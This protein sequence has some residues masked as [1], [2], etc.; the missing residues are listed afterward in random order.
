MSDEEKIQHEFDREE[1]NFE[2]PTSH[3]EVDTSP[4]E[5]EEGTAKKDVVKKVETPEVQLEKPAVATPVTEPVST[6]HIQ[7][8]Q[9]KNAPGVLVL[10]WLAYAFWGWTAASLWWL[11]ALVVGHFTN[12]QTNSYSENWLAYSFAST[13]VLYLISMAT[14]LVYAR[15]EPLH[16]T[17]AATVIM[18]IHTV[19]YSLIGIGAAITA[20]FSVV[21][22]FLET[23]QTYN[24]GA[25]TALIAAVVMMVVYA[26]LVLRILRPVS[27]AWVPKLFWISMSIITIG[28][29]A[30]SII[31]PIAESKM[32][33][34][35][36][37]IEDGLTGVSS[38]IRSYTTANKK[39]P[40][41]LS[42]VRTSLGIETSA[43]RLLDKNLVQYTPGKQVTS[44]STTTSGV[45]LSSTT[46]YNYKLC[47][48]Y[49]RTSSNRYYSTYSYDSYYTDKTTPYVSGHGAGTVCY[50]LVAKTYN[51]TTQSTATQ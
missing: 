48:K 11:T 15:K 38:G 5:H 17:G 40:A 24:D 35:D 13:L 19:V 16:K 47:V 50:D 42:D 32:T 7:V 36:R 37:L 44:Q 41:S 12:P 18:I 23:S 6:S 14:D 27:R 45:R 9:V 21:N 3:D 20:V 31:G 28:M 49:A 43:A 4:D 2:E 46:T 25:V 51:Y 10:Q 8:E 34:N 22:I 26:F 39:L 30:A 1:L 29:M 33:A